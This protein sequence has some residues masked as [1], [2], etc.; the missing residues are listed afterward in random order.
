MQISLIKLIQFSHSCREDLTSVRPK[1]HILQVLPICFLHVLILYLLF[2]C[3]AYLLIELPWNL[4]LHCICFAW[5]SC[6]FPF[7]LL[8]FLYKQATVC[9]VQTAAGTLC[10][11]STFW[12]FIGYHNC[13]LMLFIF[14]IAKEATTG[15]DRPNT[16]CLSNG[17]WLFSSSTK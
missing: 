15:W 1:L 12:I 4:C 8:K 7:M 14:T 17:K 6:K 10:C 13:R 11:S 9:I 5:N 2:T 16:N 3:V